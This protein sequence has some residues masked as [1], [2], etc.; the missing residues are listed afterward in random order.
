MPVAMKPGGDASLLPEI[1]A[2]YEPILP[3]Y[4]W[5][6]RS[7]ASGNRRPGCATGGPTSRSCTFPYDALGGFDTEPLQEDRQVVVLPRGHR[8]AGR[9][10]VSLDDLRGEPLPRWP[11]MGPDD[12]SGPEVRDS[13]QLMQLIALGSAVAVRRSRCSPTYVAIWLGCRSATHRPPLSCS[14]GR[15]AAAPWL[16]PRSCARP[17]PWLTG[18]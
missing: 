2:I 12:A 8:L 17:R 15:S 14:P 10:V 6:R 16:S 3:R 18:G 9:T 11:G 5:R 7:A 13:G 4:R 1:L